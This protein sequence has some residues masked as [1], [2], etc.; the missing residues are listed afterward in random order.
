M[1]T[2]DVGNKLEEIIVAYIKDFEPTARRTKNSG[3]STE[4]E[5]ILSEYFLVQCKVDNVHE[6]IIIKHEDWEQLKRK[7]PIRSKR[8]PI[9][10]NQ[11]KDK[12]VT[13]T[14]DVEDFFA[15]F[16]KAIKGDRNG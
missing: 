1:S 15:I 5:D 7:I 12:K 14:L 8:I 4:L 16:R 11:A 13:I 10:V 2:R 6:N 9:F 3:A